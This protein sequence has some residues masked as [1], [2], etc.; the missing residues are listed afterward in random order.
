MDKWLVFTLYKCYMYNGCLPT[1]ITPMS[2]GEQMATM[3][4]ATKTNGLEELK[5][6]IDAVERYKTNGK[7]R[8]Q[9]YVQSNS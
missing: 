5:N 8:Y 3:I 7:C 9:R 1:R 4:L 2:H 6:A